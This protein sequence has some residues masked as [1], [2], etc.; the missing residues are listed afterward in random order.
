MRSDF[1]D[2]EMAYATKEAAEKV[3]L[4]KPT[5]RKYAQLLEEKGYHFI[6]NGDRRVFVATDLKALEKLKASDNIDRTAVELADKQKADRQRRSNIESDIEQALPSVSPSDTD[7]LN[8]EKRADIAL[9]QKQ[10]SELI[11]TFKK[12]AVEYAATRE[13][14]DDLEEKNDQI[15]AAVIDVQKQY[16]AEREERQLLKDKLDLAVDFIQKIEEADNEK[17]KG[18]FKRLFG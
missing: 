18:F 1:N 6:K 7:A 2:M 8:K 13:K 14:I 10:Y 17:K 11:G 5:I 4:A 3:G 16:E 12:M 9:Y 15:L